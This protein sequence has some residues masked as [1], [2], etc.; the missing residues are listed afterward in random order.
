MAPYPTLAALG[1]DHDGSTWL[2]DLETAGVVQL[3][4]DAQIAGDLA[5]FL[6][7]ELALN[8]WSDDVGS[9]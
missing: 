2:L 7:A 5:R 4:G 1:T 3:R 8:V 6:A 9:P